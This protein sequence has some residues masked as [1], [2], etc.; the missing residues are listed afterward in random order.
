M[1]SDMKAGTARYNAVQVWNVHREQLSSL[2][3]TTRVMVEST[4]KKR[5]APKPTKRA[6]T[7]CER[8]RAFRARWKQYEEDLTHSVDALRR[9]V[10][11]QS[12][13]ST[14]WQIKLFQHPFS[15][16]GSMAKL[17][18]EY[19]NIFHRGLIRMQ[20]LPM[21]LNTAETSFQE[22]FL[23]CAADPDIAVGDLVGVDALLDQ[24]RLY[25]RSLASFTIEILDVN[26]TGPAESPILV[27]KNTI[28]GYIT[29]T[30]LQV[31]FP[32]MP[33]NDRGRL[34]QAKLLH[35][36]ITYGCITTFR[37]T[38]DGRIAAQTFDVDFMEAFLSLGAL[39]LPEVAEL[40]ACSRISPSST[41]HDNACQ[42]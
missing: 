34:L 1:L 39:S 20:S 28:S 8:G 25:T 5:A 19:A 14:I 16:T 31:L 6:K 30:T 10:V 11:L 37:F 24:W 7:S 9:E 35:Q 36:H 17:V 29:P 33:T 22:E 26:V 18:R 2:P 42:R 38:R 32:H 15:V 21:L 3:L 13:Q 40:M 4:G 41:L 12:I 23:R 27:V